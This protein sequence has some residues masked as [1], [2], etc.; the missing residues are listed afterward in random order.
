MADG[1]GGALNAAAKRTD[2]QDA[3]SRQTNVAVVARYFGGVAPHEWAGAVADTLK[4]ASSKNNNAMCGLEIVTT[5]GVT[6]AIKSFNGGHTV[7]SPVYCKE[8]ANP[9][10]PNA[11]CCSPALYFKTNSR[12]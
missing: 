1:A 7:V 3:I 4:A 5:E 12:S 10:A 9:A 2:A 11:V 8:L 6:T